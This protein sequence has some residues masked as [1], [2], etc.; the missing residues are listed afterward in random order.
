M[1]RQ[2]QRILTVLVL[3]SLYSIQCS[4]LDGH[5]ALPFCILSSHNS[6][7]C[8]M[9][10]AFYII[11]EKASD[12]FT[13]LFLPPPSLGAKACQKRDCKFIV[14]SLPEQNK[15]SL[16]ILSDVWVRR[17][18]HLGSEKCKWKYYEKDIYAISPTYW[19]IVWSLTTTPS[20]IHKFLCNW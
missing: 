7:F 19:V 12:A 20:M 2:R 8:C 13:F 18:S 9:F 4:L 17:Y 16:H 11:Q 3:N 6:S 14:V 10:S 5:V 1:W 15:F